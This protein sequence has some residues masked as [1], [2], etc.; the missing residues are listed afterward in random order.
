MSQERART[1]SDAAYR[2]AALWLVIE[3]CM[4]VN[5]MKASR[6][7]VQTFRS[8]PIREE[9]LLACPTLFH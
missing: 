6:I 9:L 8:E 4:T 1:I 7:L 5:D 2:D 3:F